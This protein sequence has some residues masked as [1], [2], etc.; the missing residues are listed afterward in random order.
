MLVNYVVGMNQKIGDE[1]AKQFAIG[2]YFFTY[3]HNP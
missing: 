1:A 2:F 3:H